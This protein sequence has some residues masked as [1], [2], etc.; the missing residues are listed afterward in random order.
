M[1]SRRVT[2][3]QRQLPADVVVGACHVLTFLDLASHPLLERARRTVRVGNGIGMVVRLATSALPDYPRPSSYRSLQL[4]ARSRE[5]LRL[6]FGQHGAGLVPDD[7]PA[8]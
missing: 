4:L 7:P 8:L 1:T 2:T 6:A 3:A 5:Q